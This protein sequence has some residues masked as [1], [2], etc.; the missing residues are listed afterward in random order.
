[1]DFT[2]AEITAIAASFVGS[3]EIVCWTL[4]PS[5]YSSTVMLEGF[6]DMYNSA[7]I[8]TGHYILGH[9]LPVING[10]LMELGLPKLEQKLVSDTKVHL[11]NRKYISASQESLSGMLGIPASKY[12]MTNPMWREANRLTPKGIE[13]TRKR[14]MDDVKQHKLL[15]KKLAELGYLGPA[16]VW[17]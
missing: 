11:T 16:T 8:V 5:K 10:A 15:R 3:K 14:V 7:D 4:T 6:R 9:D 12:H 13:L 2:T 17:G 1:M